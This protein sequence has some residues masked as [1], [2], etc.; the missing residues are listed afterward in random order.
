MALDNR[1]SLDPRRLVR[2]MSAAVERCRLDLTRYMVLT[3]AYGKC[4]DY[5]KDRR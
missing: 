4:R 2:L 3:E 1:P 5:N